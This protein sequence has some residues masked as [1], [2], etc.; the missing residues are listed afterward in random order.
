[1][2]TRRQCLSLTIS[3]CLVSHIPLLAPLFDKMTTHLISR[4]FTALEAANFI[5]DIYAGLSEATLSLP[6]TLEPNWDSCT[7]AQLYWSQT[8]PEFADQWSSY[9][10]PERTWAAR[11][12]DWFGDMP[13]GWLILTFTRR[14]LGV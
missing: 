7:N 1:M 5:E 9:R 6:I 13:V 10:T 3:Q 8:R 11:F 12:L 2:F 4:R 14:T